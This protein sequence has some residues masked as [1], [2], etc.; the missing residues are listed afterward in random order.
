[1][2]GISGFLFVVVFLFLVV[3]LL[4]V[5]WL[6]YS[7]KTLRNV[8]VDYRTIRQE[9]LND[10]LKLQEALKS[11]ELLLD[12]INHRIKNVFQL[13]IAAVKLQKETEAIDF[14][15][16]VEIAEDRLSNI[17][18]SYEMLYP[19]NYEPT[20]SLRY[21][22]DGLTARL[23]YFHSNDNQ[24]IKRIILVD[25]HMLNRDFVSGI[26]LIVNE[27][28]TNSVKYGFK[29]KDEGLITLKVTISEFGVFSMTYSDNGDF[30]GSNDI[31]MNLA[32]DGG[33]S[34]IQIMSQQ[35][36]GGFDILI[37][38]GLKFQFS[39]NVNE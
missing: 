33:L 10:N 20:I 13:M 35:L 39:F 6:V 22:L 11:K 4:V 18:I 17:A 38:K 34:I 37:D 23:T 32:G 5:L 27:L 16:F 28:I 1:M 9:C 14:K 25:D 30:D 8:I 19:K 12:E 3:L 36:G 31:F 24:E 26:G 21:Y 2:V 15:Q 29:N 7:L